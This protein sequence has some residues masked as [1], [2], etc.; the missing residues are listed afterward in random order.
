M[1]CPHCN[2]HAELMRCPRCRSAF[3]SDDGEELAHLA[4]LRRRM[5]AWRAEGL[6]PD[7][8][9]THAI[10]STEREVS[11]LQR[12]LGLVTADTPPVAPITSAAPPP[13]AP[14]QAPEPA[15][16][17]VPALRV[18]SE[19]E[20]FADLQRAPRPAQAAAPPP[21]DEI[22]QGAP[23]PVR[24]A[25]SWKQVGTYLLSERTLN[26]LL[27]LAAFLILAS[28]VV[29]STLN[30]THLQPLAHLGVMAITTL[31]FF[32][33]GGGVRQK[34]ALTKT[35]STLL[36]IGAAFIPLDIWTLGQ[37]QLP[38]WDAGTVWLVA[39]TLCLP[40]YLVAHAALRDRTFALLTA[41]AGGSELLA[42]L[43]R[44]HVPL[45]W[46]CCALVVLALGYV[47]LARRV[48]GW[49]APLAWA[50][51]WTAQAATPLVM[52]G[53]MVATFFPTLWDTV[54][55]RPAAGVSVYAVGG[56]WWLGTAFYALCARLFPRR[57]FHAVAAWTLPLAYLFTL[58]KAPWDAS[59]YNL[60]LALLAAGYLAYGQWALR[61]PAGGA[62]PNLEQVLRQ[63]VYQVSLVLTLVA[64]LWPIPSLQSQIATL[65]VLALTYAAAA[66]LL[67]QRACAYVA[68]ALVPV[69]ATL[70]FQLL[71]LAADV[72]SLLRVVLAAA[73]LAVGEGVARRTGEAHRPLADTAFGL[74]GWRSRFASPLFLVGYA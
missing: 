65:G 25:F 57:H 41:L 66:F 40:I 68:V 44:L 14:A 9:V 13:P 60:C 19:A 31:T 58:T 28:A 64:G 21:P 43:H 67:R 45:E 35:G 49:R 24:P 36:A 59:W 63:P 69:A 10:A 42:V 70:T 11:A 2:F 29:I 5:D 37:E 27:G 26:A 15:H 1:R 16:P 23:R 22:E 52:V 20:I 56:A 46:S 50:L 61:L 4:Y 73:L 47:L 33:A 34:L 53:L 38:R 32:G 17:P 6:L 62:H 74:G 51:F 18:R 8:A 7:E 12:R 30:P 54:V 39:S 55:A 71:T 3:S 48:Q 72:Q